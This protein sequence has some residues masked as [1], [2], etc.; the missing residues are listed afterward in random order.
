MS[1]PARPR[2]VLAGDW[3]YRPFA[4]VPAASQL[5]C[6]PHAGGDVPSFAGLAAAVAP[7]LEVW[8]VRLPGRGGRFGV[9]MPRRFD[10][11]VA[12]LIDGIAGWLRPGSVFYGQSFGA[13]LA[14]E[15]ARALPAALRPELLVPACAPAPADWVPAAPADSVPASTPDDE[16]TEL[17][18]RCGLDE[19]LPDDDEIR[20]FALTTIRADLEVCRSYRHRPE[21]VPDLAIHALAGEGDSLLPPTA[22]AR[23][24]M[25]TTGPF[26]ASVAAGGHLLAHPM[27]TGPADQLLDLHKLIGL[28]AG[29]NACAHHDR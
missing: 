15:V 26:G 6:F 7:E 25:A 1:A 12:D 21:P 5:V 9:P 17:L 14:Y 16:A 18:R 10:T 13:L 29:R 23:W 3:L 28:H 2:P 20:E 4:V 19:L 11:L 27:S 22:L 8:A 24:A